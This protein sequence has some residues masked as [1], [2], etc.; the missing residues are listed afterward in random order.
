[1]LFRSV[2]SAMWLALSSA[3]TKEARERTDNLAAVWI[4]ATEAY[5]KRF[6]ELAI[7]MNGSATTTHSTLRACAPF[8]IPANRIIP[9][10]S[11]TPSQYKTKDSNKMTYS[12]AVEML[13]L[14]SPRKCTSRVGRKA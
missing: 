1:M 3:S 6:A 12:T 13:A 14:L 10:K 11:V 8:F 5:K 7:L 9:A 4:N 2:L